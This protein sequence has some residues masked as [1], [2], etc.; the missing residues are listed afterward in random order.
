MVYWYVR[1]NGH[2]LTIRVNFMIKCVCV[3]FGSNDFV[4]KTQP[5][6][7]DGYYRTDVISGVGY[8]RSDSVVPLVLR[9]VC[10]VMAGARV[11]K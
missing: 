5:F 10:C 4:T 1:Y 9:R 7:M 2:G 11:V 8:L 6:P 3:D